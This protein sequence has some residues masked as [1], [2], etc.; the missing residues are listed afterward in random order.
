MDDRR[1]ILA[2]LHRLG[3]LLFARDRAIID[4]LWSE[5]FEL[6]GSE[7]GEHAASRSD[8]VQLFDRL[9]A[10]PFRIRWQ[11]DHPAVA[12]AG[13]VA[14][15][16]TEGKLELTHADRVERKPYRLVAIFQRIG[17]AWKW[18]LYSGSEPA[19]AELH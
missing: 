1:V 17:G 15:L 7:A 16:T 3:E 14:W 19:V 12:I 8:L 5:G 10:L 13:D 4:D 6:Y 2:R 18:R 9:F 11:W